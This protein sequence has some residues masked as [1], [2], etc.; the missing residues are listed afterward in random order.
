M[1]AALGAGI[2]LVV[3]A[4]AIANS[5]GGGAPSSSAADASEPDGPFETIDAG[6]TNV[7]PDLE[8]RLP[9]TVAGIEL[10]TT[11]VSGGTVGSTETNGPTDTSGLPETGAPGESDSEIPGEPVPALF[12]NA[13]RALG[14]T[15][16]DLQVAFAKPR[17]ADADILITAY[18]LPG[19]SGAELLAKLGPEDVDGGIERA[20]I[21]GKDV[22][23]LL[24]IEATSYAYALDD[25]VYVVGG[26]PE[27]IRAAIAALP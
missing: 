5:G 20:T 11:S 26:S 6:P 8:A 1:L 2:V 19:V 27:L 17:S 9:R 24:E 18:R 25:V 12:T 3:A 22:L 4:I 10:D 21:A 15:S 14:R 13:V 23:A 16:A 7:Y